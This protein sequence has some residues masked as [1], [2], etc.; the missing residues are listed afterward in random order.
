MITNRTR[1]PLWWILLTWVGIV[2]LEGLSYVTGGPSRG[3]C[4]SDLCTAIVGHV[5]PIVVFTG[6]MVLFGALLSI[7]FV[8]PV[9]QHGR[10][11]LFCLQWT[12]VLA[13][14]QVVAQDKLILSLCLALALEA[15]VLLEQV[16]PIFLAAAGSLLLYVVT[17]LQSMGA[18]SGSL[19]TR[20]GWT[21]L[22]N[23]LVLK[24]DFADLLLFTAGYLVL[25][26]LQ[27]RTQLQRDAAYRKLEA[28]NIDLGMAHAQLTESAGKLEEL[29]RLTERQRLARDLHDTLTQGLAGVILQLEVASSHHAKQNHAR[30]AEIVHGAT[31]RAREALREARAAI[32]DLRTESHGPRDLSTEIQKEID[33]FGAATGI[34]CE[35]DLDALAAV[36]PPLEEQ[37]RRAVAEA[38]ANVARH[39]QA[40]RVWIGASMRQGIVEVDVRDDGLGF[41]PAAVNADGHYGLLGLRERTQ[42]AGGDVEVDSAPGK[43]T[44]VRLRFPAVPG[45]AYR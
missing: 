37:V 18:W 20:S 5:S 4:Q 11:L 35:T 17:A 30:A 42:L 23:V 8:M 25:Y 1:R 22:W 14:S 10:W 19:D 21:S 24:T 13:V 12:I 29:T 39:A 16:V 44:T 15:I 2:Y 36:P 34:V 7:T 9:P 38:L 32:A 28:A 45:G 40:E 33:R 43:G 3:V 26:V 6:L 27:I 41:D 31:G